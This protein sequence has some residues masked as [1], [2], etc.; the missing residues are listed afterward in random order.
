[1]VG[2]EEISG[3]KGGPITDGKPGEDASF[4]KRNVSFEQRSGRHSKIQEK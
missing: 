2:G 1:M 4:R 3:E